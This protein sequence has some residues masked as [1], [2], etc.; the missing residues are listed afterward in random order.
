MWKL[1]RP[2]NQHDKLMRDNLLGLQDHLVRIEAVREGQLQVWVLT[3]CGHGEA[4]RLLEP[5]G[6]RVSA[7]REEKYGPVT[8]KLLGAS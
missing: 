6:I 2:D 4:K 7:L 1:T 3:K 8:G 5:K